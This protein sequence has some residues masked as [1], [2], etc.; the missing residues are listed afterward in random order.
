MSIDDAAVFNPVLTDAGYPLGGIPRMQAEVLFLYF[1]EHPL[2]NW[3][4]ANNGCEA[5][6]DAVCLL[7]DQLKI[8]NYKAWV[9]SGF[10]LK[11]NAGQLT[12][13]WNY[14]VAPVVPV[15]NNG[16]VFQFVLDPATAAALLPVQDWAVAI[17]QFPH[18]Y[19]S[20]RQSH[21]YIFPAKHIHSGKWHSRNKRNRKWMIECL[22]GI[23]TLTKTGQARLIFK[24][25]R[26]HSTAQAFR[27]AIRAMEP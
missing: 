21:W 15:E 1:Q 10:F 27:Q 17:T 5:R 20:L 13:Y 25:K 23:N 18:T 7:L 3:E 22:A 6:A 16:E 11:K 9:F 19:Y 12:N 4:N 14:H 24:K 2:F 26:I 8:P